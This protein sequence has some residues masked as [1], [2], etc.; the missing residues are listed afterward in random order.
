M[1]SS[2]SV[3]DDDGVGY[4][5]DL[6]LQ[7]STRA[8]R[9]GSDRI[10]CDPL[11][12][13]D[14]FPPYIS[15]PSTCFDLLGY[16]ASCVRKLSPRLPPRRSHRESVWRSLLVRLFNRT[17]QLTALGNRRGDSPADINRSPDADCTAEHRSGQ[18]S[19]LPAASRI[20][21]WGRRF[22]CLFAVRRAGDSL[23]RENQSL[24]ISRRDRTSRRASESIACE[25][26]RGQRKPL[27]N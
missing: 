1:F 26:S 13:A 19:P 14:E 7:V 24:T 17:V 2:D 12:H 27:T 23:A 4:S 22:C 20:A 6:L 11:H 18:R 3:T 9:A 5:S 8:T 10:D 21:R 15:R 25:L 16:A